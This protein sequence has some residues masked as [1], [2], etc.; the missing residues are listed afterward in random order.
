VHVTSCEGHD[1]DH[2]EVHQDLR[3]DEGRHHRPAHLH[4]D[5]QDVRHQDHRRQGHR[6]EEQ[7]QDVRHRDRR[8]VGH[9][10]R[11]DEDHQDRLVVH[12]DQDENQDQDECQDQGGNRL[13]HLGEN[14][15]R[16]AH[17]EAAESDDLWKTW[18]QEVAE[19]DD[20]LQEECHQVHVVACQEA[21][22]VVDESTVQDA[23]MAWG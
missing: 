14:Q 12:Q 8:G 5:R 4:Q 19:S 20:H 18:V 16:Y 22:L 2:C 6:G 3:Q 10:G 23:P 17:Q 11:R 21:C 1:V 9:Q 13:G 7:N 15:E